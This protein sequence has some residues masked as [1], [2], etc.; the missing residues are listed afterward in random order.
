M[1]RLS[2]IFVSFLFTINLALSQDEVEK[3]ILDW[4]VEGYRSDEMFL[5]KFIIPKF[6]GRKNSHMAGCGIDPTP[7]Q[8]LLLEETGGITYKRKKQGNNKSKRSNNW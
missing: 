6:K 4:K 3:Q 1:N 5:M 8:Y 2:L 7:M